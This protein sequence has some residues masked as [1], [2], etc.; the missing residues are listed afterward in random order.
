MGCY[1]ITGSYWTWHRVLTSRE[2]EED[3]AHGATQ[4]AHADDELRS[5]CPPIRSASASVSFAATRRR[6]SSQF[7]A[8]DGDEGKYSW[9]RGLSGYRVTDS[10]LTHNSVS[11]ELTRGWTQGM[12]KLFMDANV[13]CGVGRDRESRIHRCGAPPCARGGRDG[14]ERVVRLVRG[15]STL[16]LGV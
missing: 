8:L 3:Y 13:A 16:N 5:P 14:G 10:L 9:R 6:S 15:C 11:G 1:T 12:A 2:G 7:P 4:S